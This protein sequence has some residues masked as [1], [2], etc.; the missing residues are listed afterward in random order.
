MASRLSDRLLDVGIAADT[1]QAAIARQAVY[2]G[3]LDT[4]LLETD[5]IDETLLWDELGV[6]TGLP[7][8]E[9]AL[10]ENPVKCVNPDG[11]AIHGGRLAAASK[12]PVL[13]LIIS[14]VTG[15]DPTHGDL[16][17]FRQDQD[18]HGFA[19]LTSCPEASSPS[20]QPNETG[21]K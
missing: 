13:A 1:V 6:A 15:D 16:L 2:G 9:P 8:P 21:G 7:I 12:A 11:S 4:A 14:D 3:A 10:C 5:A 20:V 17:R 18:R 19:S